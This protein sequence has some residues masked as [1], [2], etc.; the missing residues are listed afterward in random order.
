M[1]RG[2][3]GGSRVAAS[4][5]LAATIHCQPAITEKSNRAAA[6]V[7]CSCRRR[8]CFVS[9]CLTLRPMNARSVALRSCARRWCSHWRA[10]VRFSPDSR[11]SDLSFGSAA[12]HCARSWASCSLPM[13][14]SRSASNQDRKADHSRSRASCAT[15]MTSASPPGTGRRS[16]MSKRAPTKRSTS[17]RARTGVSA[18]TATRRANRPVSLTRSEMGDEQFAQQTVHRCLFPGQ[19]SQPRTL[20]EHLRHGRIHRTADATQTLVLSKR[21]LAF[22]PIIPVKPPER[23]CQQ[24]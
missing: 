24:R 10:R 23:E 12:S 8:R 20:I 17:G 13:R 15:S 2:R 6:A 3:A 11:A 4:R 22:N 7:A 9:T 5:S 1:Y 16:L 18:T 19:R 14:N 21:Q